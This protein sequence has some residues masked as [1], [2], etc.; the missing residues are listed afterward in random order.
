VDDT[1]TITFLLAP[2]KTSDGTARSQI[3]PAAT[4]WLDTHRI[5]FDPMLEDMG[6]GNLLDDPNVVALDVAWVDDYEDTSDPVL[7]AM[8]VHYANNDG[9]PDAVAHSTNE[10]R[11]RAVNTPYYPRGVQLVEWITQYMQ[12]NVYNQ[13]SD[14]ESN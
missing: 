10:S 2:G 3:L 4:L 12:E 14:Q 1:L 7:T 11:P 13:D 8:G 5:R 6:V 9:R